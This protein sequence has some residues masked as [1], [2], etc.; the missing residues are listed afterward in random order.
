MTNINL[1]GFRIASESF[2]EKISYEDA[3]AISA[4]VIRQIVRFMLDDGISEEDI[5]K[6][7]LEVKEEIGT[8]RDFAEH[9]IGKENIKHD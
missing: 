6:Y 4:H 3:E 9:I 2:K 1:C 7:F 8:G 5:E